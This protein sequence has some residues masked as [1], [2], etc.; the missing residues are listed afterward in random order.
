MR[1][2][3][4][5]DEYFEMRTFDSV[6]PTVRE[7]TA[8]AQINR[9]SDRLRK[10][11]GVVAIFRALVDILQK[12]NED[13]RRSAKIQVTLDLPEIV[14]DMKCVT[15]NADDV[16]RELKE[17]VDAVYLTA[18]PSLPITLAWLDSSTPLKPARLF[19]NSSCSCSTFS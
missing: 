13:W 16:L 12:T 11:F 14:A 8:G 19:L 2:L 18:D 15:A 17:R 1:L 6:R 9:P 7:K 5:K 10:Y 4:L 3:E